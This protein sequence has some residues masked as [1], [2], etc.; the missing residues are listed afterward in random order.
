MAQGHALGDDPAQRVPEEVRRLPAERV[1]DGDRVVGLAVLFARR[2]AGG[3]GGGD[4]SDRAAHLAAVAAEGRHPHLL[5]ALTEAGAPP[6]A[7]PADRDALFV[8]LLRRL[9]PAM[10]D[11]G[12]GDGEGEGG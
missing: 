3:A 2:E 1:E 6:P 4:R 11:E 12:G 5:A 10:L 8:R 7:D 9:L